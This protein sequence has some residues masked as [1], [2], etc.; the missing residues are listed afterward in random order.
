M[1]S[2]VDLKEKMVEVQE[3]M[4]EV[5]KSANMMTSHGVVRG[6]NRQELVVVRRRINS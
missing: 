3:E 5:V 2:L 4:T 6:Y 1:I